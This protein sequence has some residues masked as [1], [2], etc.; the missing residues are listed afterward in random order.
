VNRILIAVCLLAFFLYHPNSANGP[1]SNVYLAVAHS[2]ITTGSLNILAET[3][4]IDNRVQVTRTG[5][6]PIHQNVGGVLFILPVAA[7][8]RITQAV[9]GFIPGVPPA[10]RALSYHEALWCG[11]LAYLLALLSL[12]CL[13]KVARV[14]HGKWAVI[15]ALLATTYGGPLLMYVTMFPCQ[16]NLPSFFL[17][18]LL[19]WVFHFADKA[20]LRSWFLLGAICGLGVFVRPEMVVWGVLLLYAIVQE[21]R[22]LSWG[23]LLSRFVSMAGGGVLFFLPLL[24]LRH[25]LFGVQG[26]AYGM[27]F[28]PAILKIS[29]LMLWGPRN[30]LFSFWPIL[31]VAIG[32]YLVGA[33]DNPPCFHA[34]MAILLL[35]TLIC[36]AN[37]FWGGGLGQPFHQRRFMFLLPCFVLY[38]A[39]LFD[40]LHRQRILLVVVSIGCI[41]WTLLLYSAYGKLWEFPDGVRGFLM[42]NEFSRIWHLLLEHYPLFLRQAMSLVFLPKHLYA[43]V[44]TP[45]V[46][47]LVVLASSAYSRVSRQLMVSCG[48]VG[49]IAIASIATVFLIGAEQRGRSVFAEYSRENPHLVFVTR[50]Y[51]VDVEILGSMVDCVAF[52]LEHGE[53]QAADHF[54][55]KTLRFLQQE[56]PDRIDDFVKILQALRLRQELGWHRLQPEQNLPGLLQWYRDAENNHLQGLPPPDLQERYLY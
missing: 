52:F 16:T 39:R 13:Y 48:I 26:S 30:G 32:G 7:L 9:A 54:R 55:D 38:L 56:A 4:P 5:H 10:L 33:R 43:V 20:Q 47:V 50:N 53:P 27:Q 49:L 15:A 37:L 42:P 44:L 12:L 3:A 31:F 6:A 41:C 46:A 36:G 23:A 22:Q 45:L 11:W 35:G 29:Y 1:D 25:V 40:R 34:L 21:K 2:I 51:E 19:L 14:Y 17:A 8:A 24:L 28:D 18:S